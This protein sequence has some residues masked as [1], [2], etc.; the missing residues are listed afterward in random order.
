MSWATFAKEA[1]AKGQTV[2]IKPRGHSMKGKVNDGDL[3]TVQPC[4]PTE[5]K[6]GDIVLA[7]APKHLD[8]VGRVLG[9]VVLDKAKP[10]RHPQQ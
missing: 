2:Q 7:R 10:A 1:L 3:V 8:H 6:V 4:D 5:L 9:D